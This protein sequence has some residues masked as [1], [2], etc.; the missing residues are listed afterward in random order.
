MMPA[1]PTV[2]LLGIRVTVIDPEGVVSEIARLIAGPGC[3][4]VNN[5]NVNAC[6]LAFENPEFRRILNESE[7]VFCDGFGVQLG[8]RLLGLRLGRRM[9][10][11]DWMDLL[12]RRGAAEGWSFFFLGDEPGVAERFEACAKSRHPALRVAGCHPGF[13]E[14]GGAE[15]RA[16]TE[17]IRALRPDVVLTAMGMPRQEIWA[18]RARGSLEHGVVIATGAL[19]RWY[20]GMERRAPAWISDHG[21]EGLYRL[22]RNPVRHFRRYVFGVPRFFLR[23]LRER[24]RGGVPG[25]PA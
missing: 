21:G 13:F 5:V 3:S 25:G 7:V 23:V 19:F 17:A 16:V 1:F 4:L 11:P 24:V 2:R 12:F 22:A 8:A 20:T 14:P 18:D 6:N 10:P 15:D 9:T